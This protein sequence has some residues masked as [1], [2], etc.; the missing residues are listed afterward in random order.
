M[1]SKG[2]GVSLGKNS[3]A[4]ISSTDTSYKKRLGKNII[5]SEGCPQ[6]VGRAHDA[7]TAPVEHMGVYH[8]RPDVF[9]PK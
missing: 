3:Q 5:G 1:V 8:C 6:Q 2:S 9:V 7:A 4:M